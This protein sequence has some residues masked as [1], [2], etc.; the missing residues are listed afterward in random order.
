[1]STE[2]ETVQ[3][4][5]TENGQVPEQV[6]MGSYNR[7]K[8]SSVLMGPRKTQVKLT[9]DQRFF[10]NLPQNVI[11]QDQFLKVGTTPTFIL[12]VD[13]NDIPNNEDPNSQLVVDYT[14][15][16]CNLSWLGT[17]KWG[18]LPGSKRWK[19]DHHPAAHADFD[20]SSERN[21]GMG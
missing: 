16:T 14:V 12:D 15:K 10:R 11:R 1:M 19:R 2:H 13:P 4:H 6:V 20:R 9:S 3:F 8:I 21:E 17:C 7:Y 18:C 5:I